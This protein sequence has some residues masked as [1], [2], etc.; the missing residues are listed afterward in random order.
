MERK[1]PAGPCW[2]CLSSPQVEKH[3]IVSVGEHVYLALPKGGL[4]SQHVMI[5]PIG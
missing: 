4:T 3:L 2:F 5:L 1:A